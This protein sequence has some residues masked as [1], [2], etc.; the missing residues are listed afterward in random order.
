ME[1]IEVSRRSILKTAAA[2][3]KS[4]ARQMSQAWIHFA[5]PGNPNYEGIPKGGPVTPNGSETM[6]FDME[7][8]FDV[9][10][11]SLERAA[12]GKTIPI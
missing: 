6:I 1:A 9:D 7:S 10:P 11:D 12:Y 5:R 3:A 4:L 8:R 2:A